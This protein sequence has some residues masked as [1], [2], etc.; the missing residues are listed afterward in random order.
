MRSQYRSAKRQQN[1]FGNDTI[2]FYTPL[3]NMCKGLWNILCFSCKGRRASDRGGHLP[4]F[5]G[6][7]RSTRAIHVSTYMHFTWKSALEV[8]GLLAIRPAFE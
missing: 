7:R 6:T 1:R 5:Q 8:S 3:W 4:M 2:L